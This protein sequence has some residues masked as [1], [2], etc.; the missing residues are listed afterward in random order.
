MAARTLAVVSVLAIVIPVFLVIAL[1]AVL[2]RT[3]FIGVE[4]IGELNRLTYYVGLPAFLFSSI[5]GATLAGGRSLVVFG[6]MAG[7]TLVL[8]PIGFVVAKLLRMPPAVV[9]TFVHAGVRGNLAFVGLPVIAL[10]LSVHG[11]DEVWPVA[12][13]AMAPLTMIANIF[14]VI[15]L[16]VGHGKP[17]PGMVRSLVWQLATNPLLIASGLGAACAAA[18]LAFPAWLAKSLSVTGQ[19]A[20]PL[21][22]LCIGGSLVAIPLRGRRTLATVASV[23]KVGVA[24]LLGWPLAR[25]F[26]LSPDETRIALLFLATPAAAASYTLACKLGGDEALAASSVAI[27]TA[28]SV[29]SLSAVLALV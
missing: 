2:T 7:A 26:G 12:L 22:L 25:W 13:L 14:G 9:G 20:L 11:A 16:L 24:P 21:A 19:M 23:L 8:I 6:V 18:G 4:L 3:R 1:G 10:A 27:S 5:S 15:L 17:G 29:V 28:L